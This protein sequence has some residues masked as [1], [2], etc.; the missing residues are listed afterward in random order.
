MNQAHID[1]D[2]ILREIGKD[3][4]EKFMLQIGAMDG[5]SF[6]EIRGYTDLFKWPGL[7]VEPNPEMYQRMVD[8]YN[9]H[10]N[11]KFEMSAIS[12][13]N[14]EITMLRIPP[15]VV[16]SGK[17]HPC[18][19]GMTSVWPP[20]NGLGSE[21]DKPTVDKYGEKISVPCITLKNLLEKHNVSQIDILAI[22][23]EGHDWTIFSQFD[24]NLYRPSYIKIEYINLSENEQEELKKKLTDADYVYHIYGQDIN[25]VPKEINQPTVKVEVKPTSKNAHETTIVTGIFDLSR[26]NA[27]DGF[28]RSFDHYIKNFKKLLKTNCPMVIFI[29]EKYEHL[30]WESRDRSNTFLIKR[31]CSSFKDSTFPFFQQVSEIRSNEDWLSQ[32]DWLRNSTQ[33][34]LELYNP[35]VMSK[36]FMLNDASIFNPFDTDFFVWVDGG[37]TNTVHEGYF[38]HDKVIEKIS[39]AIDKFLFISYPYKDGG[40]IHGFK[41]SEMARYCSTDPQYV[42]RGGVFGGHKDHIN[43]ANSLYYSI[44]QQTLSEG[45]MG[46]E[47][48]IFTIM[49]YLQPEVYH[50]FELKD[51]DAGLVA[52]FFEHLKNSTDLKPLQIKKSSSKAALYILT[53]NSPQQIQKLI[54]S[55]HQVPNFLDAFEE[56]YILDNSTNKDVFGDNLD[57]ATKNGFSIIKK[58]N[59][60][61]CGGRQFIAEHFDK[62]DCDAMAFFEDDMFLNPP[63]ENGFC[64]NGFRKYIPNLIQK[65]IK[66][67]H[68]ANFDFIK[69]SFSEFFGDNRTQWSWYNVPQDVREKWWPDYNRL[70]KHGLDPNA[71]LTNFHQMGIED[72]LTYLTGDIYYANWPQLV[73]K[74][75]N[76]KM[77]LETTWARPYEQTWMSYMF[78]LSKTGKLNSGILLSSP[79]THDRFIHYNQEERVES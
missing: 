16:D 43:K 35:M 17:V 27:G 25:A 23:A 37:I 61:I 10:D 73:S 18:F 58:D 50:R 52:P 48:S 49:S 33:A 57:I 66:I 5:V 26:E 56:K 13:Y 21:G 70:P 76:K 72:D 53:F 60:G 32:A 44:L 62:T 1:T 30:V 55:F 14:G 36:M 29:E 42:C 75:G 79:I 22:D 7:Y 67:L 34:T 3:A 40:E 54:D 11:V 71:P 64:K 59:I 19:N 39:N 28:K 51:E 68:R 69:L 31:E 45:L 12:D 38:T 9:N 78:Q 8:S 46:T 74:E 47:E 15:E 2:K 24:F 41:R 4:S 77:F 20:R 65:S 6:D 63:S